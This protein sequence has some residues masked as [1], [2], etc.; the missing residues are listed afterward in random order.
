MESEIFDLSPKEFS[1]SNPEMCIPGYSAHLD[2][3]ERI[4]IKEFAPN[5]FR[6][7]RKSKISD[8]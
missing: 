8:K 1:D 4:T 7:L 5:L 2:A 6:S 3:E